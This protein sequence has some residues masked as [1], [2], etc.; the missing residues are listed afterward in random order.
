MNENDVTSLAVFNDP[1]EGLQ[2][3]SLGWGMMP[4]IVHQNQHVFFLES[5]FSNQVLLDVVGI[6][7]ATAQ[8]SLL[9]FV[10]D[11]DKNGLSKTNDENSAN[12]G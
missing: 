1:I 7:M 5:L 11:A 8:L 12:A 3:I 2:N 10:V 6:V 9:A 4:S